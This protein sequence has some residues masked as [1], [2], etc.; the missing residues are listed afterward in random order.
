M[1][2]QPE[3]CTNGT[4]IT[5]E[6]AAAGVLANTTEGEH[7]HGDNATESA[8]GAA[9]SASASATSATSAGGAA[10]ATAAGWGVI[11]AGVMGAVALL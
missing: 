4:G 8:S 6:F 5:A 3:S 9:S 10:I 2:K 11:G 1:A 7:E